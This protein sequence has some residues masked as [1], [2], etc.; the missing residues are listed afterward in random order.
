MNDTL[1]K[2]WHKQAKQEYKMLQLVDTK[3]RYADGEPVIVA[4]GIDRTPKERKKVLSLATQISKRWL[5][6]EFGYNADITILQNPR[7]K[8][9]FGYFR[10]VYNKN[11]GE[12]VYT[13]IH[14]S[15]RFLR[16]QHINGIVACVKHELLHYYLHSMGE[17]YED[18]T[19][20][21]EKLLFKYHLQSNY[22]NMYYYHPYYYKTP[23][24]TVFKNTLGKKYS[25]NSLEYL[26]VNDKMNLE[27]N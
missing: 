13:E 19:P 14:I 16:H 26:G 23:S 6:E 2:L 9:S 3:W 18:G 11:T 1:W 20:K 4:E 12:T 24:E 17:P 21:F 5:F 10:I 8:N 25:L 15:G 22:D 27:E 7:L